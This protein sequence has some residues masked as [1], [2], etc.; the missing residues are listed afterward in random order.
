MAIYTPS[1]TVIIDGVEYQDDVINNLQITIGRNEI[2]DTTLPGYCLIELVNLS[3]TSPTID[4]LQTIQIKTTDSSAN[5][6][7]LFTGEVVTVNNTIS[8]AGE[9]AVVNSLFITG[10]GSLAKLVRKNAGAGAYPQE[11]DGARIERILQ[12]ALFTAWED[13]PN[14]LQWSEIDASATWE[15]YG[16]QGIDVVDPGRYEI[17]ARAAELANA[18]NLARAVEL[19]GLGYLYENPTDGT[20]GYADAERRTNNIATNTIALDADFLNA[21]LQTRLSTQDVI[22]SVVVVYNDGANES[23][24][25][26][27]QSVEDYG[28][29]ESIINTELVEEADADEQASR[30]VALRGRPSL[31]L[32]SISLNLVNDK[33]D[34]TTRDL[35]MGLSMDTYLLISNIPEGIISSGLFDGFIEGWTWVISKNSLELT[36]R[37]SA[38]IFSAQEVQWEDF[39]PV[40]QWQNL[41]NDLL[42]TD[43]A[44]G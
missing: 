21:E 13:L 30:Y 11:L 8:G 22:N 40:T 27:N 6:I 2:F 24:A 33:I 5:D 39:N 41:S 3:G 14:T 26:N 38:A 7:T 17:I 32:E 12:D 36:M 23:Q 31:N 28:L 43:L 15:T 34:N 9:A 25:I 42:W 44:I 35:L 19:S 29:I 18:N 37:V 16:Q 4:L 1:F 20:I 10:V